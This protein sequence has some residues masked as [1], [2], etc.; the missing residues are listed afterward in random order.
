MLKNI[1]LLI[2]ASLFSLELFSFV[3]TEANMLLF[4]EIPPIYRR[5][6]S[7]NDWRTQY[8]PWG[9]WHRANATDRQR[10]R[11]FDVRY[12]SNEVGARDGPFSQTKTGSQLRYILL[13]D[14]FAEGYG[15]DFEETAQAQ[16][17]KLLGIDVYNFGSAG[18]FGPVQYFLIYKDLANRYEHDGVLLFFLPANDF[19]DNDFSVWKDFRPTWYR[20]YYKKSGN[21]QYDIFYPQSAIRMAR[22]DKDPREHFNGYEGEGN[23]LKELLYKYTFTSNALR[24]MHYLLSTNPVEKVGYSGYYD[25]PQDEQKA[26]IYFLEKIVKQAD[27]RKVMILIIPTRGDLARIRTGHSY[28][29]Q[30]WFR[31][32]QSVQRANA[33]VDVIDMADY[34]PRNYMGYFLSCDEHWSPLGN[35]AAAQIIAAKYRTLVSRSD[36]PLD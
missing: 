36:A 30:Y 8:E 1:A 15:V 27:P 29:E 26:A 19:T 33:N 10:T 14:S 24:T 9:S 21:D 16:I 34:M 32:L 3:A 20:P 13:G 7:G 22:L 11:C 28:K 35:L 6:Y 5:Q 25:A 18:Y 17:E 4:N 2:C 31:S 12:Q 23:I